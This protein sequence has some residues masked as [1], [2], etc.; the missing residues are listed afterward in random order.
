[1][2]YEIKAYVGHTGNYES[3]KP[4]WFDVVAEMS[5]SKI[6]SKS[7]LMKLIVSE[8]E[9]LKEDDARDVYFYASDGNTKIVKDKYGEK[10]FTIPLEKV[11]EAVCIDDKL[12]DYRRIRLFGDLL[13]SFKVNWGEEG[14]EVV[15]FGY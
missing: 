3:E 13:L 6:G 12:D 11:L 4:K 5:L 2:G 15:F 1:M 14:V 8:K 10:L 9:R 7:E